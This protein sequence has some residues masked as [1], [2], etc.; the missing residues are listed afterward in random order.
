MREMGLRRTGSRESGSQTCKTNPIFWS[1][2]NILRPVPG[3]QE[4]GTGGPGAPAANRRHFRDIEVATVA[5]KH[6]ATR[7]Q[8][9]DWRR[10]L[11]Q[12][13]L[14]LPESAAASFAP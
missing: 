4:W 8:V 7:W 13:Q 9:Y 5:R 1:G 10:R 3:T 11:R 12:G 2:I 6:G 14:A